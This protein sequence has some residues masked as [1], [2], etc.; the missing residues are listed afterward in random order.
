M[1]AADKPVKLIDRDAVDHVAVTVLDPV[2]KL[3]TLPPVPDDD[4]VVERPAHQDVRIEGQA[5]DAAVV[6]VL[7]SRFPVKL[8]IVFR[9]F[10]HV[11]DVPV[12]VGGLRPGPDLD[13]AVVEAAQKE[14]E[15]KT[16][17][18]LDIRLS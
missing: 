15:Q 17:R 5:E 10:G 16:S 12:V 13:V 2:Q 1:G 6:A 14:L 18:L 3:E 11:V 4:G 9:T 8:S 7:E